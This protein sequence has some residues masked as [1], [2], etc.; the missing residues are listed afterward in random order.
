VYA[1]RVVDFAVGDLS[2][3]VTTPSEVTAGTSAT[4]TIAITNAGPEAVSGVLLRHVVT[5]GYGPVAATATAGTCT[6]TSSPAGEQIVDCA[7]GALGANAAA[8]VTVTATVTAAPGAT[9][10]SVSNVKGSRHTDPG[11]GGN[12]ATALTAVIAPALT[13]PT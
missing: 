9:L 10:G 3:A 7:F 2:V 5:V 11:P 4:T 6:V 1:A 13:R 8:T 12:T